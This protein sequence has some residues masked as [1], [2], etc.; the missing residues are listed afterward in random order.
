LSSKNTDEGFTKWT[1]SDLTAERQAAIE[2]ILTAG[3]IP[4][5]MELFTAG[6]QS[7]MEVIRRWIEESDVYLLIRG[8]QY[9]SIEPHSGKSYIEHEYD[10]AVSLG[11]PLFECVV[12]KKAHE[13]QVQRYGPE[14]MEQESPARLESFRQNVTWVDSNNTDNSMIP[15]EL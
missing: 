6:D 9:G 1:S 2:A 11:K 4:A 5:G 13:E 15:K 7:Q 3:H 14:V 10:F 12:E 8:G